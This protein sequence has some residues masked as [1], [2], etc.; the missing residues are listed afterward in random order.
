MSKKIPEVMEK[1]R[2]EF[3]DG[4]IANE[5]KKSIATR[6]FD[7]MEY[8]SGYGFNR[9]HSAA[10]ALISYR[11]A[12]L[13]ANFPVEFMCALLTSEKDNT[14]KIVE[15]VKESKRMGIEILSPDVQESF[16]R[17]RVIGKNKIRFGLSAVKNIGSGAIESIVKARR[18]GKFKSLYDF[19]ERVDL[20][21]VN[22]KVTESLI[23]C[24]AFDF[25]GFYRSQ[26]MAMIDQAIELGG[27]LQKERG[28]GQMSFFDMEDKG[29]EKTF[30]KPPQIKE[31]PQTQILSFEKD[32]LGFYVSG[33]PLA[34]YETQLKKM[35]SYSTGELSKG[36]DNH[37][38]SIA[39]L[40]TKVKHTTT[41][42][43]GE[44]M[45]I[46][47]LEDFE[48]SVEVL[49]FPSAFKLA[50]DA[51]KLNMIVWV[52]GRLNLKEQSPKIIA[53]DVKFI[54]EAYKAI[55][56]INIELSGI[57]EDNLRILKEKIANYPGSVPVYLNLSTPSSRNIQII[58]GEEL[59]VQPN[60]AL[61]NE[62][63]TILGDRK[64]SLT[65]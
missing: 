49:V 48:G 54:D 25:L 64:F 37:E 3:T 42:K 61:L 9:S 23:K 60:E 17:F 47:K 1:V 13:K 57:H 5:I 44:R 62:L 28:S 18:D 30:D 45:A 21:L 15:Y 35:S 59:Y 2:K 63:E 65:L 55:Q 7:L 11:T 34:R 50:S 26:L 46:F 27:K 40:I 24:G 20:R 6:V 16:N 12:Y 31:W 52:H 43:T 39:G 8:F 14:D 4:C 29:F 33:H 58:V 41:R 10:Y 56:S 36:Q 19:S 38:I 53:N 22:R 32:M 51:L